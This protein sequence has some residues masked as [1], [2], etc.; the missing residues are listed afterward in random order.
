MIFPRAIYIQIAV[1]WVEI[2]DIYLIDILTAMFGKPIEN[3]RTHNNF[4]ATF[5]SPYRASHP[6]KILRDRR[7]WKI[8]AILFVLHLAYNGRY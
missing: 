5:E 4:H 3:V 8:I 1:R 7:T 2:F 6:Y